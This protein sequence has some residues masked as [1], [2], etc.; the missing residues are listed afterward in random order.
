MYCE[1]ITSQYIHSL[2]PLNNHLIAGCYFRAG[3]E[4]RSSFTSALLRFVA[5]RRTTAFRPSQ[6]LSAPLST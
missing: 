1:V 2:P 4:R 3:A 6:Y 5:V